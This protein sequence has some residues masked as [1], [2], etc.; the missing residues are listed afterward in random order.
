MSE[1]N[2]KE[3][4]KTNELDP[5]FFEEI[6]SRM[7]GE[8]LTHCLTCGTC[9][10]GCLVREVDPN[11]NPRRIVHQV[12]LGMK[13]YF[14]KHPEVPYSCNLCGLCAQNCPYGINIGD[15]CMALREW[16][17]DQGVGPL[18]RHKMMRDDLAFVTSEEYK[19]SL[20]DPDTGTCERVFFPG[21]NMPAYA[22]EIVLETWNYL[23]KKMP[24]T[25]IILHCCGALAHDLGLHDLFSQ[26]SSTL[27]NEVEGLGATEL[28]TGCPDCYQTIKRT[29]PNFHVR[30]LYE[31]I[32][33]V[34]IP[35]GIHGNGHTFTLHDSCKARWEIDLQRSVRHLLEEM[36][37]QIE[38][39][40]YT[41]E[42]T[43]CCG[44]GG[45][46]IALNPFRVVNLT[47]LR[48][49]DAHH[50]ML[51]YCAACRETFAMHRSSLHILDLIFNP[52][53]EQVRSR[54]MTAPKQRRANQLNLKSILSSLK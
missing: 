17:V 37:F 14:I 50:D 52:D 38:D 22:P 12:V 33:G 19:I 41:G 11:F 3:P 24:G 48:I 6:Q 47:K 31:V 54:S 26:I 1:V 51:S 29:R 44:Q 15:L 2:P 40:M 13:D 10:A 23:R 18:P 20:P 25:G 21:C 49:A 39:L 30:N 42:L 28:I 46:T 5:Q 43:R 53:W 32:E 8:L 34:G 36:G 9:T 45:L 16:L 4:I 27:E 7:G 35:E